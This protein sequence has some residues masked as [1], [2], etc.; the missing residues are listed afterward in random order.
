MIICWKNK[1]PDLVSEVTSQEQG[2]EKQV[3][4]LSLPIH[5]SSL[6]ITPL[7]WHVYSPHYNP[8]IS[9]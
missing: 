3:G 8:Y 2:M 9:L 6:I 1:L 5:L 4:Y 7:D